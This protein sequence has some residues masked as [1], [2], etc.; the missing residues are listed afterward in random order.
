MRTTNAKV[1][2]II[3]VLLLA[4]PSCVNAQGE[5]I[6]V[7]SMRDM[8]PPRVLSDGAET[9]PQLG[10][11]YV[12]VQSLSEGLMLL[13]SGRVNAFVLIMEA[14]QYMAAENPDVK[15]KS[16]DDIP[17]VMLHLVTTKENSDMMNLVNEGLS[18]L[19]SDGVLD[20][21]WDEHVVALLNGGQPKAVDISSFEDAQTIRVGVSG[22]YPPIDY[23]SADGTPMGYNT[24]ILAALGEQLKVNIELVVVEGGARYLALQSGTIDMF[25]WQNSVIN[26]G[27]DALYE[28]QMSSLT[29]DGSLVLSI[30]Y[31]SVDIGML[32]P[33]E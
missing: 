12:E 1:F 6:V 16:T 31:A 19:E 13:S 11:E 30:P 14:A 25:F 27:D 22:D 24:A 20:L 18:V 7:A 29:K 15:V 2:L 32:V 5:V 23:V 21:L 10:Y 17:P 33:A 26:H 28:A 9:A 4:L 3:L 8:R